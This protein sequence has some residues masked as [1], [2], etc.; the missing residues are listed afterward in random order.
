MSPAKPI[1]THTV[2]CPDG[3]QYRVYS[4]GGWL[5]ESWGGAFVRD[6]TGASTTPAEVLAKLA[7]GPAPLE[8]GVVARIVAPDGT[9]FAV[10]PD[11]SSVRSCWDGSYVCMTDPDPEVLERLGLVPPPDLSA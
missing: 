11:G 9:Q 4:D 2:V 7:E 1:L 10:R 5:Q 8:P 3:T 6:E